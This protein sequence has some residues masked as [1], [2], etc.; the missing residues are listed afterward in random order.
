M[1]KLIDSVSSGVPAATLTF[2]P[3]IGMSRITVGHRA[4]PSDRRGLSWSTPIFVTG[5]LP[6]PHAPRPGDTNRMSRTNYGA[7]RPCAVSW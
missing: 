7:S 4:G 6:V 2:T 5:Y 1:V 3:S